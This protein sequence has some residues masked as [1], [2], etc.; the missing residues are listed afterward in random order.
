MWWVPYA[1]GISFIYIIYHEFFSGIDGVLN[2]LQFMIIGNQE[3][4]QEM[5]SEIDTLHEEIEDLK[6]Q[7]YKLKKF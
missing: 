3:A 4:V 7:I 6:S 1:A 2:R 5:K